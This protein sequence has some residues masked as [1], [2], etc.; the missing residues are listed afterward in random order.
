MTAVL[1]AAGSLWKYQPTTALANSTTEL[2]SLD[3]ANFKS[4][5]YIITLS[6]S[7]EGV[8]KSFHLSAVKKAGGVGDTVFNKRGDSVNYEI[9]VNVISSQVV[10]SLNNQ[11]FF[12]LDVSLFK[13]V[14]R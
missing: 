14:P 1:R 5:E 7:V 6:N 4:V 3:F 13:L 2:D 9:S 11:E 10:L 12:G 8:Y